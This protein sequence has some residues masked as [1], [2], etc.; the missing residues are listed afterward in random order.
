MESAV[1]SA[2]RLACRCA[3]S[4]VTSAMSVL[5]DM[6]AVGGIIAVDWGLR[7]VAFLFLI[8]IMS[9]R[10]WS[11][12]VAEC[13]FLLL[14][15]TVTVTVSASAAP[16]TAI[17]APQSFSSPPNSPSPSP[18]SPSPSIPSS[19]SS[20]PPS[21]GGGSGLSRSDQIALGCGISIPLATLLVAL[22]GCLCG[23][24]RGRR[25]LV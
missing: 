24:C 10:V 16:T 17:A 18:N 21:G 8:A 14:Q 20:S 7:Y 3:A 23:P 22:W 4:S 12:L 1:V 2:A 9:V 19:T 25:N 5:W 11:D 6:C 15:G 13:V